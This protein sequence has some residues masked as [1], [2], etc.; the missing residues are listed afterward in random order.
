MTAEDRMREVEEKDEEEEKESEEMY[1]NGNIDS[2]DL[3]NFSGTV[4]SAPALKSKG[5]FGS[6]VRVRVWNERSGIR[7]T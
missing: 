6:R 7:K 3:S 5:I 1:R 4:A 2:E